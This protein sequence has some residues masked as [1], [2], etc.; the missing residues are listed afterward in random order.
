MPDL[1]REGGSRRQLTILRKHQESNTML[2]IVMAGIAALFID[3]D[4]RR[5]QLCVR[6]Q[7]GARQQSAGQRQLDRNPRA[8]RDDRFRQ[9][10][11]ATKGID[12]QNDEAA[13]AMK[14][15]RSLADGR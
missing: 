6:H 4:R 14:S 8:D 1:P 2:A 7:H 13:I 12:G 11:A 10:R 5:V 3:R 15:T 9:Q